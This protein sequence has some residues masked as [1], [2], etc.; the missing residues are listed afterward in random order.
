MDGPP[1]F[2]VVGEESSGKSSVLERLM[3]T[4]LLP[5]AENI[6]TRL[7]IHVRLRRSD[8]A[9]PQKLE[10]FNLTTNTTERRPYV[11]AAQSGAA[12]DHQGGAGA[13]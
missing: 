4:P 10:V 2:V 3:M 5:R 1:Q 9:L 11:I 13:L 6:C 8:R 12:E 7:P